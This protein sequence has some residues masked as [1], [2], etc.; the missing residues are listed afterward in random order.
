MITR[1][2]LLIGDSRNLS[3]LPAESVHLVVSSPPYPMIEMWDGLFASLNPSVADSLSCGDG[4][5][6]FEAMHGELDRVWRQLYRVLC[7]GGIAC[8]NLGDATRSI[9]GS[10][11]L[12]SNHTRVLGS[13]LALGFQ[14]LPDIIW[15]KPTNS[16]TKFLGSGTLPPGAYVTLEHEWVLIL[17]KG[18]LRRFRSTE[19][20]Q[21]RRESA[22]FWEERN[23]WFSDL[24]ELTGSRQ[25]LSNAAAGQSRLRSGA[26]P[27]ELANRLVQMFSI[28]GDTVLD[29]FLG[30]GTT[31][32]AAAESAR[33][34]IGVEIDPRLI[35]VVE[36]GLG[37]LVAT[38][39]AR[40][41][42]RLRAHQEFVEER[43]RRELP[44]AH[45]NR[46]YG[47]PVVSR[48]EREIR[49][50]LLAS[51]RPLLPP[52]GHSGAGE[53]GALREWEALYAEPFSG[54]LVGGGD[55]ALEGAARPAAP[56]A[57]QLD[58][59]SSSMAR[60]TSPAQEGSASGG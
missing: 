31:L 24:W 20:K 33:N 37:R 55:Q 47:F 1:H 43:R 34:C 30:S 10:F 8:L 12:Y 58:L 15:R 50:P 3:C 39:G 49:L 4:P 54:E 25:E 23:R 17:R 40:L 7:P 45:R 16:P 28:Q 22:F 41:Q 26:F 13:C 32:F 56:A 46:H 27:L 53:A 44:V 19:E 57:E 48:Q 21:R 9:G 52:G 18:G 51:V 11:Q 38:A 60:G 42:A 29:P 2:R 59:F 14:G 36:A 6:S 5:S 35:P